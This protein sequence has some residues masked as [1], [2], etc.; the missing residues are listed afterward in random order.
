MQ[1]AFGRAARENRNSPLSREVY[2]SERAQWLDRLRGDFLEIGRQSKRLIDYTAYGPKKDEWKMD[3]VRNR[4]ATASSKLRGKRPEFQ[5]ELITLFVEGL[6]LSESDFDKRYTW[7]TENALKLRDKLLHQDKPRLTRAAAVLMQ[8][9][10]NLSQYQEGSGF[11]EFILN[12]AEG[13][14]EITLEQAFPL[15][16]KWFQKPH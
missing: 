8:V 15:I 6:D 11:E 4:W 14:R 16:A 12:E 2:G 5:V 1:E 7:I 10:K 3:K 9:I 13:G